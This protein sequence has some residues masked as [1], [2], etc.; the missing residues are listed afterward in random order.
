MSMQPA[1]VRRGLAIGLLGLAA[2]PGP[3][4]RAQTAVAPQP[5]AAPPRWG[6]AVFVLN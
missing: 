3:W 5:A 4:A 1:W 2:L 6:A